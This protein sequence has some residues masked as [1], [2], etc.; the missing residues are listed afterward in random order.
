VEYELLEESADPSLFEFNMNVTAVL[1]PD[2]LD[3]SQAEDLLVSAYISG[4]RLGEADVEY[5]SAL[6]E[7]RALLLINGATQMQ[8]ARVEFRVENTHR[9]T[10]Y[11]SNGEPVQFTLDGITGTVI[12]PYKLFRYQPESHAFD[13]EEYELF[14]NIP[15]PMRE[16]TLI[17]FRIPGAKEVAIEIFDGSG[18]QISRTTEEYEQEG[19]HG[20]EI[21]LQGIPPGVYYYRMTTDTFSAV[22]KLVKE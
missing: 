12:E 16:S 17:Q 8:D 19:L 1:D 3:H 5:V 14:Q 6:N 7:Y 15:N 2:I 11:F 21:S 13:G 9:N 18:S 4:V 20:M 10:L 22:K